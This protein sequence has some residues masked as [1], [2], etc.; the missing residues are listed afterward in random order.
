[1]S[2]ADAV[3]T[4]SACSSATGV[5]SV[6][7][8]SAGSF[9]GCASMKSPVKSNDPP[10][11]NLCRQMNSA[12]E[13]R[14]VNLSKIRAKIASRSRLRVTCARRVHSGVMNAESSTAPSAECASVTSI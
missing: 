3:P 4:E 7:A 13:T 2:F 10:K 14:K 11:T 12:N 8:S 9:A 5:K 1:M 6:C